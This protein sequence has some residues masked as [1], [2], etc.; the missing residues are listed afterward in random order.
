MNVNELIEQLRK[1]PK[2]VREQPIM[3][4]KPNVG[5]RLNGPYAHLATDGSPVFT[6]FQPP[7]SLYPTTA[8]ATCTTRSFPTRET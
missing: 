3:D 6:Q 1:L 2:E 4:G 7:R 8:L 5:Y